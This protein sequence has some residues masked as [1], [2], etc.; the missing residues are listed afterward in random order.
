MRKIVWTIWACLV[1]LPLW[2]QQKSSNPAVEVM[3][4][5][6]QGDI[7]LRWAPSSPI[8]WHYANKY[9]Y[10]VVRFT[11]ARNGEI[12]DHPP[13]TILGEEIKPAPLNEWKN[14]ALKNDYA[15]V[16]AQCLYGEDV[17]V[18][19]HPGDIVSIVNKSREQET[20]F[21]MALL[22]ADQNPEIARLSGLYFRDV[23]V[24]PNE[25]YL[26]RVYTNIP[27]S[28]QESDTGFVYYG[29]KDFKGLPKPRL[30][31]IDQQD[32][33]VKVTW[34]TRQFDQIYNFYQVQRSKDGQQYQTLN[35]I[36][37]ASVES[38]ASRQGSVGIYID[39][40]ATPGTYYYRV[41]GRNAFGQTGPPSDSLQYE[42][43]KGTSLGLPIIES[44]QNLD[45][46]S[47]KVRWKLQQA[48]NV[49]KITL[50]RASKPDGPYQLV[51][52][53]KETEHS[54]IDHHPQFENYYRIGLFNRHGYKYSFPSFVQLTDSI[55]PIAPQG[56][57]VQMRDSLVA[58]S[59]KANTEEDVT[60]YQIF[61]ANSPQ[62]EPSLMTKGAYPDTTFQQVVALK[63]LSPKLYYYVAAIDHVGNQSPLS[64]PIIAHKPDRVPPSK[65]RIQEVKQKDGKVGIIWILSSSP[66][67]A[68][69]VIYRKKGNAPYV[70]AGI[71]RDTA[72]YFEDQPSISENEP[73]VLKYRVVAVDKSHNEGVSDPFAYQWKDNRNKAQDIPYHIEHERNDTIIYWATDRSDVSQVNVYVKRDGE[74]RL[75]EAKLYS[76]GRV[77][78]SNTSLSTDS[79][80][81]IFI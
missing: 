46:E 33:Q 31:R 81:L 66:D 25:E 74:W 19:D 12:L 27:S 50:E 13:K 22:A 55:P 70:L 35:D 29:I 32:Q 60:G 79:I 39:T 80:K 73:I 36:P 23:T 69:Y 6:D 63:N 44:V 2:A 18:M 57:K 10:T 52:I 71:E 41:I 76:I 58:L 24:R 56:L 4:S 21:S 28:I 65:P 37:V 61:R 38:D 7:L 26:Y 54:V 16:A 5:A 49:D 8:L 17:Q 40:T 77:V 64:E 51:K 20:R 42:V 15:A 1:A 11:Y 34:N 75:T 62:E 45:N 48:E 67:V 30:M 43:T 53:L 14:L 68:Q 78:F 47:V 3:A 9:G 72:S 59:W